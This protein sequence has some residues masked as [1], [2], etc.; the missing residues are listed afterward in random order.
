M[1]GMML[2]LNGF[3]SINDTYGHLEGDAAL[4]TVGQLLRKTVGRE[5]LVARYAG[6]EFVVIL[7]ENRPLR[8]A[9]IARQLHQAAE[10]Y[11]RFSG[12]PY[13][14]SFSIGVFDAWAATVDDFFRKMDQAMYKE[15]LAFY[16]YPAEEL[17]A[18]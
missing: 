7:K 15:K 10:E 9:Q 6:D 14:I 2:D 17:E 3:K 12:K 13:A 11:N 16:S 4:Q 8:A 1:A 5:C 18:E